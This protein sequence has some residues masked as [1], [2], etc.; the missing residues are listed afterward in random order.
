M[1]GGSTVIGADPACSHRLLPLFPLYFNLDGH[2]IPAIL[3]SFPND[4]SV[5]LGPSP[6]LAVCVAPPCLGI[7][8]PTTRTPKLEVGMGGGAY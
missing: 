7:L 6:S 5:P 3:A 8:K 4:T 1:E 2:L